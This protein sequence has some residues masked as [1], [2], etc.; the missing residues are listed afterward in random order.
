MSQNYPPT[1]RVL[2]LLELLQ[3]HGQLSGAEL[4]SRLEIDR[5]SLRRY[6][7]MLEEMGIPITTE[8][9]RYGG[10]SLMSGY[11]IPPMMFNDDEAFALTVGLLAIRKMDLVDIAPAVESASAKLQRSLP[12]KLKTRL[13]ATEVAIQFDLRRTATPANK[14]ILA[15][16][17]A[18][19]A[20]RQRVHMFYK[21]SAKIKSEREVDAYGLAFHA[22]CWYV[23]GMCHLRRDIRSFRLDRIESVDVL[24]QSFDLPGDFNILHYLQKSIAIIPRTNSVEVLLKT[25][26]NTA[27][28]HVPDALAVLE[29]TADGVALYNQSDDLSW[30]ARQLVALPFDFEVRKPEALRQEITAIAKRLI[31]IGSF[32]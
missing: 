26:I 14:E 31:K 32:V 25:D 13:M 8:R 3:A 9:G 2:A 4:S 16:L 18:A 27:R 22:N 15:T 5:R 7:V 20:Q 11:K 12:E 30:F 1:V 6:I 21:T 23:V 29:Q 19:S 28:E 24:Q 17:S 10:Y